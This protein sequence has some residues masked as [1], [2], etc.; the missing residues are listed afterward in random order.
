MKE[1]S[2][3]FLYVKKR[4]EAVYVSKEEY[5][6]YDQGVRRKEWDEL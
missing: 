5:K 1:K 6:D 2:R 3:L 4:S